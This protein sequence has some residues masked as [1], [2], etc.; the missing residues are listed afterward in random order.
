MAKHKSDKPKHV[1]VSGMLTVRAEANDKGGIALADP[2]AFD[3]A[4]TGP[5]CVSATSGVCEV[6][7]IKPCPNFMSRRSKHGTD[8]YRVHEVLAGYAI[9]VVL[10]PGITPKQAA[11][12]LALFAM[13]RVAGMNPVAFTV[14]LCTDEFDMVTA[15]DDAEG[16]SD[17]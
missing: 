8:E 4:V 6:V 5:A 9:E 10:N 13:W 2:D 12:D 1:R 17:E 16:G 15:G 11:E 7:G 14:M 3:R